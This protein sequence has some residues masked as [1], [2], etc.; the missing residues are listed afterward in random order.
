MTEIPGWLSTEIRNNVLI[1]PQIYKNL[2]IFWLFLGYIF[3]ISLYLNL[4]QSVFIYY[5]SSVYMDILIKTDIIKEPRLRVLRERAIIWKSNNCPFCFSTNVPK[6]F[7]EK[8]TISK[9]S[10]YN[11]FWSSLLHTILLAVFST[12]KKKSK[13]FFAPIFP[14]NNVVPKKFFD[15][16]QGL[17]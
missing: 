7:P 1:A 16:T 4:A 12:R 13:Q 3:C 14:R 8:L 11:Q 5:I 2:A 6:L 15:T 9:G 10:S 17:K